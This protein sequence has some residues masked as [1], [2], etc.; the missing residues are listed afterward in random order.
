MELGGG[1]WNSVEVGAW[2]SNTL[3]KLVLLKIAKNSQFFS[4]ILL[5][6]TFFLIKWYKP[7]ASNFIWKETLAEMFFL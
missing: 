3:F 7:I 2:F 6:Q 5:C 4:Q 1:R